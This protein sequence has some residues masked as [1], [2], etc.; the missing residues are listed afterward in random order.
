MSKDDVLIQQKTA[1]DVALVGYMLF[2]NEKGLLDEAKKFVEGFIGSLSKEEVRALIIRNKQ[3]LEQAGT[4]NDVN[5]S[6]K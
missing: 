6:D 3:M 1:V 4:H 5:T 2:L